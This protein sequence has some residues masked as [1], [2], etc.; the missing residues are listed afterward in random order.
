VIGALAGLS[1]L[2]SLFAPDAWFASLMGNSGSLRV[3]IDGVVRYE[4][5]KPVRSEADFKYFITSIQ[6]MVTVYTAIMAPIFNQIYK[7]TATVQED[8]PF[9]RENA[10]RLKRIG[11]ILIAGSIVF[12]VVQSVMTSALMDLT[13]LPGIT[14]VFSVDTNLLL[15]GLIILVLGGV[16]EYGTYLQHEYDTTV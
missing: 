2:V 16:F 8:K 1:I 13:G 12:R 7:I 6:V 10:A 4:L 14:V 9:A 11:K 15:V 5:L 3:S